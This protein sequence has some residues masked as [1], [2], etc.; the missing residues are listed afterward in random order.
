[1]GRRRHPDSAIPMVSST[2]G[3]PSREFLTTQLCS[4]MDLSTLNSCSMTSYALPLRTKALILRSYPWCT[5]ILAEPN[6]QAIFDSQ[7]V[8]HV[9]HYPLYSQTSVY[10]SYPFRR[11]WR[12]LSASKTIYL[13]CK[14]V[15]QWGCGSCF[16]ST[17]MPTIV[18]RRQRETSFWWQSSSCHIE[19]L[20]FW[21]RK[22]ASQDYSKSHPTGKL[23]T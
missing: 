19:S 6:L 2:L 20:I 23:V 18:L 1:M 14:L 8:F 13:L 10:K 4:T 15:R 22:R 12:G 17:V 3:N 21:S 7:S 5:G 11:L 9:S 16:L